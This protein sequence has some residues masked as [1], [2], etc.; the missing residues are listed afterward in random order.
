MHRDSTLAHL[1][2]GHVLRPLWLLDPA[3][4]FLNHGSYGACPRAVLAVQQ[5]WRAQMERQPVRFMQATLPAALRNAACRLAGFLGARGDDLVFVE[6]ATSG[7]N[8]VL[9]SLELG[10]GD[11]IL[12]TSHVYGAVRNAIRHVCGGRGATLIEAPVPF[13]LDGAAT[14]VAAIAAR[15]GPRTRLV[16]V[17]AVTS[18][19]ATLLPVTE[20][21]ALCQTVGV[22]L[23]VDAAHAP[24]MIPLDL[25]TLGADWVTGNAHKWLFAPKGCA[26]LWAREEAQPGLHP[27][28]ISH[29]LGRGFAA[30][31]DWVGTRDPSAWLTVPA[32]MDFWQ[33]LG[34][35][36]LM[37]RNRALA[38]QAAQLLAETWDTPIGAP[39]A[40][41]AAMAAVALPG[42]GDAD[43][44]MAAA[45]HD[46]LWA[47]HR[48]E[49]PIVPF[50]G[51]LWVRVS[52]QAYNDLDDYRRL[53]DA[54]L[55]MTPMF[56]KGI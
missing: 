10:A 33:A 52:A 13:P 42:T 39:A 54:V 6:N 1:R 22:R 41:R 30:E 37:A 14:V 46:R 45:V 35:E 11:E 7:I 4:A 25:P 16:V 24:G 49:V 53:A 47:D 23:L 31:F 15:L 44:V 18:P 55:G 43:P 38:D 56:G 9:R 20:I 29:G 5:E 51:R 28:V 19:T 48:I 36:E 21:A 17:D 50:A 32:A 2:H 27:V 34:G 8:A 12:T 3:A 26:F 40:M